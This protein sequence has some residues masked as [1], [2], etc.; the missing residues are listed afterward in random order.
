LGVDKRMAISLPCSGKINIQY[1][2][3]AFETGADGVAVLTC[4]INECRH[5]EGNKRAKKRVQAIDSLLNE[6]GM[7]TGRIAVFEVKQNEQEKTKALIRDFFE[8][9]R[10]ILSG[11]RVEAVT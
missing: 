9:V 8:K 5:L 11:E 4:E 10:R 6:I 3:K 1:L 2:I 7:G